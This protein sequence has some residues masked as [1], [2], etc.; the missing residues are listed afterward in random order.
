MPTTHADRL[1]LTDDEVARYEE[2]GFLLRRGVLGADEAAALRAEAHALVDRLGRLREVDATWGSAPAAGGADTR[3]HLC[4]NA[5]FQSA[6]FTR[7]LTDPRV[8]D[9]AADL[10]GPNVQLH[11]DKLFVK[12]PG[13]GSPFPLHQDHPFFPHAQGRVLA[14]IVHL[15]DA[16]VERGCVT[17]VPGSHRLGPLPHLPDGGH[18][19]S[20]DEWP[21]TRAQPVEARAGDVL[22]FSYLTVHGSGVNRSDEPRT[23]FLIQMRAAEDTPLDDAHRS[24]GQGMMLRG[25]DPKGKTTSGIAS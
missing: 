2:S 15:D 20:T 25:F 17:V 9:A 5:Q 6:A 16:P 18:H 3:L 11:H 23:T 12:P 21:V 4:H 10:I 24:R 7:L 13:R 14:A 8:V 22:Y 19:L 1:V